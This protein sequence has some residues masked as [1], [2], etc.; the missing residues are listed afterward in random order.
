MPSIHTKP[1]RGVTM[2]A[3]RFNG[4]YKA[5]RKK[6]AF[7]YATSNPCRVPTARYPST[8]SLPA[9]EMAGYHC[10]MPTASLPKLQWIKYSSRPRVIKIW[11]NELNLLQ[12][13]VTYCVVAYYIA[14]DFLKLMLFAVDLFDYRLGFLYLWW[15]FCGVEEGVGEWSSR[16]IQGWNSRIPVLEVGSSTAGTRQFH[17]WN[18]RVPPAG[19]QFCGLLSITSWLVLIGIKTCPQ[20]RDDLSSMTWRPVLDGMMTC[21]RWHDILFSMAWWPVLDDKTICSQCYLLSNEIA[22]KS[23]AKWIC[24]EKSTA[25]YIFDIELVTMVCSRFS[26]FFLCFFHAWAR[27]R[28]DKIMCAAVTR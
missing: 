27:A 10:Q 22:E 21:S 18:S 19:T 23:T 20:W 5:A 14:V 12:M 17:C 4:W 3:S 9:I 1:Q 13:V 24:F 8:S 7:R 26:W 28:K 16:K 6:R 11:K 25:I 2:V 15:Y